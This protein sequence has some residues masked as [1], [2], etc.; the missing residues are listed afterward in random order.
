ML[1]RE[2]SQ[3]LYLRLQ[4]H[5]IVVFTMDVYSHIIDGMQLDPMILLDEAMPVGKNGALPGINMKS[6]SICSIMGSNK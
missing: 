2:P 1:L 6:A 4:V 5:V 3:R